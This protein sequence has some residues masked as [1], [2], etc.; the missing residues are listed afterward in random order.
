MLFQHGTIIDCAVRCAAD[1]T[2]SE[3][4]LKDDTSFAHCAKHSHKSGVTESNKI[5]LNVHFPPG[6]YGLELF[7]APSSAKLQEA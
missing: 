2:W 1:T 6:H 3:L 7:L 5:F 4:F